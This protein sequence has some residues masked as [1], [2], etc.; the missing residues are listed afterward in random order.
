MTIC[1]SEAIVGIYQRCRAVEA[2]SFEF[3]IF[4]TSLVVAQAAKACA[5]RISEK[6][7]EAQVQKKTWQL[8]YPIHVA[9][10]VA[11]VQEW[12]KATFAAES[13]EY[14][15][16]DG[17]LK[18]APHNTKTVA[19]EMPRDEAPDFRS[20]APVV[21]VLPFWWSI[22]ITLVPWHCRG[23]C[24][25][26]GEP[27]VCM[28]AEVSETCNTQVTCNHLLFY[29]VVSLHPWNNV[30]CHVCVTNI[31]GICLVLTTMH[32]SQTDAM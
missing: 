5:G 29:V 14:K 11:V 28:I 13:A 12:G 27:R 18:W 15:G 31:H 3:Y 26:L 25:D 8:D 1:N 9:I 19:L 7:K 23:Q 16:I 22:Q 32:V 30:K 2:V 24:Y 10:W 17:Y 4:E 6:R 20:V 21:L